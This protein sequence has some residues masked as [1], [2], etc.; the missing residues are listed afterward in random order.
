[1]TDVLSAARCPRLRGIALLIPFFNTLD[2]FWDT[3]DVGEGKVGPVIADGACYL[4]PAL[5]LVK[6]QIKK[7]GSDNSVLG[8]SEVAIWRQ[9]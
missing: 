6:G 8:T 4:E 3:A 5:L 7:S 2:R 1:M 9:Q